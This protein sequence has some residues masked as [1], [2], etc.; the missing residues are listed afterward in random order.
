MV[1][2]GSVGRGRGLLFFFVPK[3]AEVFSGRVG[4]GRGLL[5]FFVPR[6]Q[7]VKGLGSVDRCRAWKKVC[8]KTFLFAGAPKGLVVVAAGFAVGEGGVEEGMVNGLFLR[9][10]IG[11]SNDPGA[12]GS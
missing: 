12:V 7:E 9:L 1:F 10:G 5:F 4:S 2:S 8:L 6:E 3:G 11:T